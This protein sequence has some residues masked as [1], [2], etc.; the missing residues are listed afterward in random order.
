[1]SLSPPLQARKIQ[2]KEGQHKQVGK[3][4]APPPP[5][6]HKVQGREGL[7]AA[8]AMLHQEAGHQELQPQSYQWREVL[9]KI[10][11]EDS[12]FNRGNTEVEG[13]TPQQPQKSLGGTNSCF[14]CIHSQHRE[15]ISSPASASGKDFGQASSVLLFS[16]SSQTGDG[17]VLRHNVEEA[18]EISAA[19]EAAQ[20]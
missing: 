9:W 19:P 12:A 15:L 16:I 10:G 18:T 7:A 13:K 11:T 3:A 17:D 5:C 1:M 14:S 6:S 20:F 2:G 4:S 8:A